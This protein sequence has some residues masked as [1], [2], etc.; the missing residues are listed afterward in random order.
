MN[1]RVIDNNSFHNLDIVFSS[2][3][4]EANNLRTCVS[5]FI[6]NMNLILETFK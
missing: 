6:I 1:I 3:E 4:D 5:S 2:S